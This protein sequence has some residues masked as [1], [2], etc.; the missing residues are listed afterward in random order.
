MDDWPE[1]ITKAFEAVCLAGREEDV[2]KAIES[3]ASRWGGLDLDIFKQVLEEGK[4]RDRLI[5]LFALG[6]SQEPEARLLLLPFLASPH[7]RERWACAVCLGQLRDE[8]AI[9]VLKAILLE[10]GYENLTG[11]DN[12]LY[13]VD[14]WYE[15]QRGCAASLLAAWND[16]QLVPLLR[17]A[18]QATWQRGQERATQTGQRSFPPHPE[19]DI[20]FALGELGAFGALLPLEQPSPRLR[21]ALI[22]V[23]LGY[24]YTRGHRYQN[25]VMELGERTPL[26]NEV[27]R[28]LGE[29]V[30]VSTVQAKAII[31][32]FLDDYATR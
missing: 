20:A 6:Y 21:I 9:P 25:I 11:D 19:D 18:L 15:T 13:Q 32:Q 7:Q 28:V 12:S 22:H 5:A 26:G 17:Q 3:F 4:G 16:P 24:L 1:Y 23:A 2:E 14:F 8:R 29:H 30:G 31:G 10:E 27:I